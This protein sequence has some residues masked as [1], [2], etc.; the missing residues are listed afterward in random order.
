MI[1]ALFLSFAN[2]DASQETAGLLILLG[3]LVAVW[4]LARSASVDRRLSKLIARGQD[5]DVYSLIGMQHRLS[6][7]AV[8][9][10]EAER[11]TL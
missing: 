6:D 3:G 9:A 1:G 5:S 7:H 2:A 8:A 10:L 11:V 4:L